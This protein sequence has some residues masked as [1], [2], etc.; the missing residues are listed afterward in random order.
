MPTTHTP[1]YSHA[2]YIENLIETDL[3][4]GSIRK[5]V[6]A[7]QGHDFDSVAF[8][9]MSG[10]LIAPSIALVMDKTMLMVRKTHSKEDSHSS[11]SVEG[12]TAARRYIIVDD[13]ISTGETAQAIVNEVKRFA[14][15]AEC[16]G[17]LEINYLPDNPG[18][19][20]AL[21]RNAYGYNDDIFNLDR[22]A[23]PPLRTMR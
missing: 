10:A 3:L 4:R 16:L 6:A 5:A 11:H 23:S 21:K 13:F 9:G 7:L 19:R 17:V 8:R 1:N 20:Y 15:Y 2:L 12:D 14:P 18:P 22:K